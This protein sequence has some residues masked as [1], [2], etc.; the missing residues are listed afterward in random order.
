MYE[1]ESKVW[2]GKECTIQRIEESNN[3]KKELFLMDG[4]IFEFEKYVKI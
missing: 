2:R 1:E 3:G 4:E